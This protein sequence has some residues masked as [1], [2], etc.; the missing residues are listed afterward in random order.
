M[1]VPFTF[2]PSPL[3]FSFS[4][5]VTA[6][7]P[8]LAFPSLFPSPPF[9]SHFASDVS[10]V[11]QQPPTPPR[12]S[13]LSLIYVGPGPMYLCV[14]VQLRLWLR[15]GGREGCSGGSKNTGRETEGG[16][17]VEKKEPLPLHGSASQFVQLENDKQKTQA[18][19]LCGTFHVSLCT[20]PLHMLKENLE[21]RLDIHPVI[22]C[23]ATRDGLHS[24]IFY[25]ALLQNDLF[26]R[27]ESIGYSEKHYLL[28]L[29]LCEPPPRFQ[30]NLKTDRSNKFP[31]GV[32]DDAHQW[33]CWRC[34]W[35]DW[36]KLWI[37]TFIR[38]NPEELGYPLAV[39]MRFTSEMSQWLSLQRSC[40]EMRHTY[41]PNKHSRQPVISIR[42][43]WH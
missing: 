5:S 41:L 26:M 7:P 37:I 1:C 42:A 2:F 3:A 17:E 43:N 16:Q 36:L 19:Q 23:R 31:H 8:P 12:P 33:C 22:F 13:F 21:I 9:I 30:Y 15:K 32:A 39:S 38:I 27:S 24:L 25:L 28:F 4:P 6:F 35:S 40:H 20:L 18:L 11:A 34:G 29:V 14:R 10:D